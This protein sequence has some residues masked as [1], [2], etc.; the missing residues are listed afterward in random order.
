MIRLSRPEFAGAPSRWSATFPGNADP[1]LGEFASR[2]NHGKLPGERPGIL[3][4]GG[5]AALHF[6]MHFLFTDQV[7][8]LVY[9][10]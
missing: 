2:R 5:Y 6:F 7:N 8:Q 9:Q 10:K 3:F 1:R 4:E